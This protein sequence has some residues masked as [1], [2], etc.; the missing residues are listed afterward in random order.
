MEHCQ[1]E[2]GND[3]ILNGWRRYLG[4]DN[5]APAVEVLSGASPLFGL[6]DVVLERLRNTEDAAAHEEDYGPSLAA[7]K[8]ALACVSQ[9]SDQMAV[10]QRTFDSG[11]V[12][13]LRQCS[14]VLQKDVRQIV[15]ADEQ[16]EEIRLSAQNLVEAINEATDLPPTVRE[17]LLRYAHDALRDVSLYNVN[18]ADA[19]VRDSDQLI[20]QARR[21][22]GLVSAAHE[23]SNVWD[24]VVRFSE[25][26]V[27]ITTLLHAPIAIS[28]DVKTYQAALT[29]LAP[30]EI[31]APVSD[32]NAP[33]SRNG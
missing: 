27:V 24:A 13:A 5:T 12:R 19:L 4:L 25:A 33:T 6:P 3:S 16:L 18:G 23:H 10:M 20:G 21:D 30:I 22:P 1:K 11:D 14:R 29:S 28:E 17:T 7:T 15:A 32:E 9:A 2:N 31:L 8:A 26:L